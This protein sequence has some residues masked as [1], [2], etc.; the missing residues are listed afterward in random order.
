M[1]ERRR[2]GKGRVRG[3]GEFVSRSAHREAGGRRSREVERDGK[4]QQNDRAGKCAVG[5]CTEI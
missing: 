3:R 2:C 5:S 1:R 4:G